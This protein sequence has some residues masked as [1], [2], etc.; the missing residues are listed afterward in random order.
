MILDESYFT[1]G[2][3]DSE[4][5]DL[6][7]G[8]VNTSELANMAGQISTLSIFNKRN[9]ARY[10][11]NDDYLNSPVSFEA[12]IVTL[13]ATPLEDM[14]AYEIEK[15]IFNKRGYRK[16]YVKG[17]S[18]FAIIDEHGSYLNC[19]LINPS[20]I[21]SSRDQVIGF[22]FTVEC[23]SLMFWQ[24]PTE[25]IY[26]LNHT[27]TSQQSNITVK[28][29]SDLDDYI[30]PKITVTMGGD[31]GDLTIINNTDDSTRL[32]KFVDLSSNLIIIV[33][34]VNNTVS[35]QNYEKMANRNFVR[36]LPGSNGFTIK[37][38]VKTIKYEFQNRKYI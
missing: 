20:R 12:E 31:G 38:E 24:D 30:Y 22:R 19:R 21:Y 13:C 8:H 27:T 6:I 29:D 16:L 2:D 32:T 25:I 15:A 18:K 4:E 5:Y 35:G 9:K 23:D 11:I 28:V 26:T 10:Y 33:N 7:F 14:D 37:G 3:F 34:G 17:Q 1:Y 36:L